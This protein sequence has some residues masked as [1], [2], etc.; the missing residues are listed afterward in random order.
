M[1]LNQTVFEMP[2]IREKVLSTVEKTERTHI[3]LSIELEVHLREMII[4]C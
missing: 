3:S 1:N 2:N 4:A